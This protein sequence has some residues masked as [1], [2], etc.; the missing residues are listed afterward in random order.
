MSSEW[1]SIWNVRRVRVC[2]AY[3]QSVW[4]TIPFC[5]S[6]HTVHWNAFPNRA[7]LGRAGIR[8]QPLSPWSS[9][10]IDVYVACD[11]TSL[12]TR[13]LLGNMFS[14]VFRDIEVAVVPIPELFGTWELKR[15]LWSLLDSLVSVKS[16]NPWTSSSSEYSVLSVS[17]SKG[18]IASSFFVTRWYLCQFASPNRSASVMLM[19]GKLSRTLRVQLSAGPEILIEDRW[20]REDGPLFSSSAKPASAAGRSRVALK[21]MRHLL[22]ALSW[23]MISTSRS[24][25]SFVSESISLSLLFAS[26]RLSKM[27]SIKDRSS[28]LCDASSGSFEKSMFLLTSPRR[29]FDWRR[30]LRPCVIEIERAQ[31][32]I[33]V[34]Y[35]FSRY[36]QAGQLQSW[37]RVHEVGVYWSWGGSHPSDLRMGSSLLPR[38]RIFQILRAMLAYHCC[39]MD[40]GSLAAAAPK[41]D[42]RSF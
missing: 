32:T 15:E 1:V 36:L 14:K 27:T 23:L 31:T 16:C 5:F 29:P 20:L 19:P 42:R 35:L 4:L 24:S 34:A 12:T 39:R 13:F 28:R 22:R 26:S 7:F 17:L 10:S 2:V 9:V 21:S 30:A 40:S 11:L 3:F 33:E 18:T 37:P 38:S 41:S 6:P 25:S 8:N